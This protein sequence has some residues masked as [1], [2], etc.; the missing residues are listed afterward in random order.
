MGLFSRNKSNNTEST[1]PKTGR[2]FKT[3]REFWGDLAA[4][5]RRRAAAADSTE[6]RAAMEQNARDFEQRAR[7]N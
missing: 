7:G 5:A 2:P 4:D 1:N 3:D 6:G